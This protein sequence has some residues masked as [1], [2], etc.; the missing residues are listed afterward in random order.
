V[1]RR[2]PKPKPKA[3]LRA[4]GSW[5]GADNPSD[6]V[7]PAG[8]IEA[9]DWLDAQAKAYWAKL[10]PMLIRADVYKAPDETALA[11][12]CQLL[13]RY[14]TCEAFIRK[15][16]HTYALKSDKGKVIGTRAFPEV[17][18][19]SDLASQ[20]ARLDVEFGFTPSARSRIIAG[21][22]PSQAPPAPKPKPVGAPV[23]RLAQ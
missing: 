17:R 18:I 2:G 8:P 21:I 20:I 10:A 3:I 13:S 23:M 22:T 6:P 14:R 15:H 11:R 19:A 5:R 4:Q 16:G 7:Y 1:G 9:P 12:Y